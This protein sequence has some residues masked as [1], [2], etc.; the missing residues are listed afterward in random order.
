[1]SVLNVI[2]CGKFRAIMDGKIIEDVKH[3]QTANE[4]ILPSTDLIDWFDRIIEDQLLVMIKEFEQEKSGWPL[5]EIMNLFLN[6]NKY[7]SFSIGLSTY[8][9]LPKYIQNKK[10]VVNIKNNDLY[11]FFWSVVAALYSVDRNPCLRSSYPHF[12]EVL[13]YDDINFPIKFS[14]VPKF[15]KM[16]NLII[17]I[18]GEDPEENL[19]KLNIVPLYL[20]REKSNLPT[21]HILMTENKIIDAYNGDYEDN[22]KI[23]INSPIY[24]FSWIENLSRLVWACTSKNRNRILICDRCLCH[25]VKKNSFQRHRLQ[26]ENMNKCRVILVTAE[27]DRVL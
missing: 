11:C 27:D 22:N 7:A 4:I 18:Y 16:N 26:C 21:I 20:S 17:N 2:L 14:D 24:H 6:I 23:E 15:E 1:M 10:A 8:T 25:S 19:E 5:I 9:S 13:K 12:N 3:F